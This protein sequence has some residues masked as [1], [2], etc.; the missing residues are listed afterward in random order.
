MIPSRFFC[1][2]YT[3]TTTRLATH[4]PHQHNIHPTFSFP[5]LINLQSLSEVLGFTYNVT[6]ANSSVSTEE[7]VGYVANGEFDVAASGTTINAEQMETVSFSY[8]YYETGL[9]FVYRPGVATE[10]RE[11]CLCDCLLRK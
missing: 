2:H 5:K 7:V 10:V 6:V 9:S 11:T 8:P 4:D 1:V 3:I